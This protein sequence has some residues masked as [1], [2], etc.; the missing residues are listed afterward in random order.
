M[1][2]MQMNRDEEI[3]QLAYRLWQEEGCPEGREIQ[4]WIKAE[5]IWLEELRS[6]NEPEQPKPVR[7]T[8]TK[9]RKGGQAHTAVA[10]Q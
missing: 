9:A 5:S 8:R 6:K 7:S 4:H 2:G 1:Q 3:R 10:A